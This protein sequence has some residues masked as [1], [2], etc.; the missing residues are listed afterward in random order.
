[1]IGAHPGVH[2]T[3]LAICIFFAAIWQESPVG[4][5]SVSDASITE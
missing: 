1:M 4:I 2:G 3:C 5:E